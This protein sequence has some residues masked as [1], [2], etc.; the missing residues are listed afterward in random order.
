MTTE[1]TTSRELEIVNA[2]RRV[3][4]ALGYD[5]AEA[6]RVAQDL[7]QDGREDWSSAELLLLALGELTKRDPDRRDLVSAAEAAEILG[8]SRQRVHQLADRDDFPR[9]RYEL[10]TGKLW[11]R[12]D[13]TE[14]NKRWERK[15]GR[16]RR[17]K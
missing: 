1:N 2:V 3:A 11:T 17:A 9:P 12:A 4:V 5:D 15:T 8:V 10:A 13:I 6:A 14:F 16:P 7:E